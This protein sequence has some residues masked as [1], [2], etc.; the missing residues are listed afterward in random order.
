[1]YLCTS[2]DQQQVVEV[3]SLP[4]AHAVLEGCRSLCTTV[5]RCHLHVSQASPASQL[6]PFPVQRPNVIPYEFVRQITKPCNA[7]VVIFH[8]TPTPWNLFHPPH[9][10]CAPQQIPHSHARAFGSCSCCW[11]LPC[12][13]LSSW[14]APTPHRL[15]VP[16]P[17]HRHLQP[18][19][20]TPPGAPVG[21]YRSHPLHRHPTDI[22]GEGMGAG[23]AAA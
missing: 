2:A 7:C 11:H 1:M 14:F 17:A 23:S 8:R 4:S 21:S 9:P 19:G 3:H 18:R 16:A 6:R 22:P 10:C 5:C 12:V 20:G 13:C 15:Q